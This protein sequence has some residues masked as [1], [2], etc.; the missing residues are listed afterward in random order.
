MKSV[1]NRISIAAAPSVDRRS[2]LRIRTAQIKA[3]LAANTELVLRYWESGRN[4]IAS[5]S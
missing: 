2:T 4:I 1:N 5:T 3:A